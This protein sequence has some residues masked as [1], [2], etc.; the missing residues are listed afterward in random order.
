MFA[1]ICISNACMLRPLFVC[2]KKKPLNAQSTVDSCPL[3]AFRLSVWQIKRE[4]KE[5]EEGQRLHSGVLLWHLTPR[6][7]AVTDRKCIASGRPVT[8]S[9]LN[10]CSSILT[11][12]SRLPLWLYIFSFILLLGQVWIMSDSSLPKHSAGPSS[13]A[14]TARQQARISFSIT[15]QSQEPSR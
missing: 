12:W 8:D 15:I 2:F 11:E 4:K 14:N 6:G 9:F 5:Q 1:C 13:C 10:P 3:A 7:E